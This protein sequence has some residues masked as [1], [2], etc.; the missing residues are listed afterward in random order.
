[1]PV[2]VS[3][4]TAR[5]RTGSASGGPL[6]ITPTVYSPP[7]R[8]TSTMASWLY[9]AVIHATSR[10]SSSTDSTRLD[11]VIPF[12]DPSYRGL[13]NRGNRPGSSSASTASPDPYTRYDGVRTPAA[14]ARSLVQALSRLSDI[15]SASDPTAGIPAIS[16]NTSAYAS[17]LRLCAA[18]VMFTAASSR[19]P[20][21][22]RSRSYAVP[23]RTA[24]WP[25]VISA[26]SSAS[27][28]S[29]GSYSAS[30]STGSPGF[31]G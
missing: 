2:P 10:I 3:T 14:T 26:C 19:S 7:S 20:S 27:T 30:A 28:V 9:V 23:T 21:S 18:S 13:T 29:G 1:M 11:S 25:S 12:D 16:S 4:S 8:N 31:Q 22:F 24:V 6:P 17:R 15:V 5:G